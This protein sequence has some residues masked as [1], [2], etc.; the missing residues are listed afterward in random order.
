MKKILTKVLVVMFTFVIIAG[1]LIYS[2]GAKAST[3]DGE[4]LYYWSYDYS[5]E[6]YPNIDPFFPDATEQAKRLTVVDNPDVPGTKCLEWIERVD[7]KPASTNKLSARLIHNAIW[8]DKT[9]TWYWPD[10]CTMYP[11]CTTYKEPQSDG[12][13]KTWPDV[14]PTGCGC[15]RHMDT[16]FTYPHLE[17]GKWYKFSI[18]YKG[19]LTEMH[20]NAT[21]TDI[22]GA[23][24]YEDF[25]Q[26]IITPV[27]ITSNKDW[28][29]ESSVFQSPVTQDVLISASMMKNYGNSYISEYVL[30]E[31][32]P[33]T[34]APAD[35]PTPMESLDTSTPTQTADNAVTPTPMVTPGVTRVK[36]VKLNKSK[37]TLTVKKSVKLTAKIAPSNATNKKVTWKSSKPKIAKVSSSGTVKALKKGKAT[38]T[39]TAKDGS[40]KQGKCAVTVKAAKKKK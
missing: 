33:P 38:I 36:T 27:G 32:D 34:Q 13:D 30:E 16:D 9:D 28:R 4:G 26:T 6:P 21:K 3:S 35:T 7:N 19:P 17:K 2:Q 8:C 37:V 31:V 5:T 24:L 1:A 29:T 12:T 40:K 25:A 11:A 22:A 23:T 14:R 15:E 18:T 20:L 39:A 10:K